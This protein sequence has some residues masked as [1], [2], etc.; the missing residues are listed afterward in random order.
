[1]IRWPAYILA[2]VE[3]IWWRR[4]SYLLVI[5]VIGYTLLLSPPRNARFTILRYHFTASRWGQ[6]REP[7]FAKI[8][9]DL[10]LLTSCY[11]Y[12][13]DVYFEDNMR[14][15]EFHI[16]NNAAAHQNIRTRGR[17][18]SW[19]PFISYISLISISL[20]YWLLPFCN[21][22]ASRQYILLRWQAPSHF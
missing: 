2:K 11:K 10:K 6:E 8:R 13:H 22:R 16:F 7:I 14:L 17:I 18:L 1:M 9:A 19:M 12:T 4:L 5:D 15:Y 20:I 21:D 3:A